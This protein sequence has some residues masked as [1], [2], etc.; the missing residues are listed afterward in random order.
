MEALKWQRKNQRKRKQP[1]KKLRRRKNKHLMDTNH[2]KAAGTHVPVAFLLS[3]GCSI[4][5]S[6]G[7][8]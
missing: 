1:R 5:D 8:C 4:T 3:V 6:P 7:I 2:R